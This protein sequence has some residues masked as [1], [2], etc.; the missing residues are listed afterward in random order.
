M[1]QEDNNE[2]GADDQSENNTSFLKMIFNRAN[3]SPKRG[4]EKE[5]EV[6]AANKKDTKEKE[7]YDQI[8]KMF[9]N[10]MQFARQ[11]PMAQSRG[12]KIPR[13]L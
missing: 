7:E 13:Y 8:I 6:S 10:D 11:R 4:Q 9:N 12:R 3:S 5:S 1:S 2:G